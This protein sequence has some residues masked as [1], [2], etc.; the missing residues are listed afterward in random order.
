MARSISDSR[1]RRGS[2]GRSS[3]F[4]LA[5]AAS[6]PRHGLVGKGQGLLLDLFDGDVEVHGDLL[7]QVKGVR[8]V[9][10]PFLGSRTGLRGLAAL[11]Q[12][13][14]KINDI[15]FQEILSVMANSFI[16]PES[17]NVTPH[18]ALMMG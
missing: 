12:E 2:P 10:R 7:A 4:A 1:S 15:V 14:G 8:L 5:R 13:V 6:Q 17:G 3:S 18:S 9:H 16:P 11:L